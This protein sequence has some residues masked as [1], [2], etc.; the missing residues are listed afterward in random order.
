MVESNI[1]KPSFEEFPSW[2]E[3]TSK[4]KLGV[5]EVAHYNN[6]LVRM[7]DQLKKSSFWSSFCHNLIEYND[8][9]YSKFQEALLKDINCG[10]IEF[11][12]KP[13]ASMIEK[14]YRWD[15]IENNQFPEPP[16]DGWVLPCNWLT[17]INDLLRATIAVKYLD[18]VEFLGKR[19]KGFCQSNSNFESL[20]FV[21]GL[22]GYYAAHLYF[23]MNFEVP[24]REWDTEIVKSKVEIQITTQVKE[25][26]KE[27][28]HTHYE[29]RR[30][31][32]E[33]VDLPW[34]W[35]Y[36]G[37]EFKTNYLGHMIHYIE[38]IVVGIRNG[39][40]K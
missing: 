14:A 35:Q 21:S 12:R 16:Q 8:E 19:L 32:K 10:N 34:S 27:L 23:N 22:D 3:E 24:R 26:I 5:A 31:F 29:K 11:N 25:V 20:R 37:E 2:I 28:L 33:D 15:I 6:A 17:N 4:E 38:G 40:E 18:G 7:H 9:Y 1:H 30:M 36:D 13:Y 39:E